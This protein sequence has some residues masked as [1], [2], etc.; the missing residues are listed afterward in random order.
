MGA[1]NA[2]NYTMVT[3]EYTPAIKKNTK[4]HKKHKHDSI[5]T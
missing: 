1:P 2:H 5:N 3:K 4:K